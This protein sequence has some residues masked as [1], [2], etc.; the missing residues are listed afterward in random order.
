ME[1][2]I[3]QMAGKKLSPGVKLDLIEAVDSTHSEK[4]IAKLTPLRSAGNDAESFAE[5]LYGGNARNGRNIFLYNSTAQ[6]VRCHGLGDETGTVGPP[7]RQ[8]GGALTRE[9]LLQALIEPSARLAPGFGSV[10]ITLKD[11]QEV[12]GILMEETPRNSFLKLPKQNLWKS[13]C[14]ESANV[15]IFHQACRPCGHCCRKERSET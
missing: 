7:L 13:L 1:D 8:I 2:L 12:T 11:N 5:T 14:Q 10:K 6:C 3:N 9:Q 4:L 15:K